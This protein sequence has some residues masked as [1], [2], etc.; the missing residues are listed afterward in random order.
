MISFLVNSRNDGVA[1][2]NDHEDGPNPRNFTDS[3]ISGSNIS[4]PDHGLFNE[5]RISIAKGTNGIFPESSPISENQDIFVRIIDKD[6]FSVSFSPGG[7][8]INLG[9]GWSGNYILKRET[10]VAMDVSD[11][12][13]SSYSPTYAPTVNY[14]FSTMESAYSWCSRNADLSYINFLFAHK[15]NPDVLW[16]NPGTSSRM[17][18]DSEFDRPK[19][20][21]FYGNR[22]LGGAKLTGW[23]GMGGAENKSNYHCYPRCRLRVHCKNQSIPM[24][25][26]GTSDFGVSSIWFIFDYENSEA[27][28]NIFNINNTVFHWKNSSCEIV[29]KS[30]GNFTVFSIGETAKAYFMGGV[31]YLGG[32]ANHKFLNV[33]G[34][35][36]ANVGAPSDDNY[37]TTESSGVFKKRLY[38]AR[39]IAAIYE[40]Y[41][42]NN[43]TGGAEGGGEGR[44][45]SG[46]NKEFPF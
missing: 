32:L 30:G 13:S 14:N 11:W 12:V 7:S 31:I 42:L 19:N 16:N 44:D 38:N 41:W 24:W 21:M 17:S 45:F 26:R 40:G 20:M 34:F 39:Q 37:V 28:N 3:S 43:S 29:N 22:N 18:A 25:I 27:I 4:I 6:N 5:G 1:Y 23:G 9:P 2:S 33:G 8:I 15:S 10:I 35:S 36:I 46:T